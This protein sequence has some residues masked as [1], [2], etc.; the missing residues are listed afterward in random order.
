MKPFTLILPSKPSPL[1][2][3][4]IDKAINGEDFNVINNEENLPD[5]KGHNIL[6]AIELNSIGINPQINRI[7]EELVNRGKD[8]LKNSRGSILI[9]SGYDN[10]TKTAAQDI[11][12][13]ANQ[14]GC[15][16]PGRPV[17]EANQNLDNYIPLKKIY[18]L[19]LEDICLKKSEELGRRLLS[20]QEYFRNKT[21]A[22]L[23]SSNKGTSNTYSLWEMIKEHLH[24]VEI[25]E[26]YLGNG[27][28]TDCRGCSYKT[29]KY[30]GKQ[31]KCFYGGV[32][33]E[34][35][36]PA[37]QDA[38]TIIF[39]CPNYNDMITANIVATI[40]R[41][42]A[43]FR[44]T[45]FYDKRIFTVIVSGFSGGDA[46]AK[47]L[48]SSLNM[49]KTFELPPEFSIMATANDPG[50]I[51]NVPDINAKAEK[52]AKHILKNI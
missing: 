12:F 25:N 37:I 21:I 27:T 7:L 50:S 31:T 9:H 13:I 44:K 47:Q 14:L 4:M 5:L 40:N 46:L 16:F 15:T 33:V 26:V 51:Y 8:S 11:V 23:H 22:V 48:I 39:L 3:K 34:E 36:Y 42:T 29:C 38:S 2:Q 17:I 30:F 45:K 19:S 1:L 43:L 52:F 41:L 28:I 20:T 6:F 18:D 35:V 10:F 32:V 49:N 24:D